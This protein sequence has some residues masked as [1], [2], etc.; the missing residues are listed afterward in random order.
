MQAKYEIANFLKQNNINDIFYL[1]GIHTISLD[2]A[3][4]AYGL[5]VIMGRHESNITFMADGYARASGKTGVL[6]VT[7]GPG[8]G[9]VV[10]GCM[11]AYGDDTPLIIFHIDTKREEHGRGILHELAEPENIFRYFIKR[12]YYVS[13]LDELIPSLKSAYT[14]ATTNRKGPTI[15]SIPFVFLDREIP[16][17]TTKKPLSAVSFTEQKGSLT[18]EEMAEKI[19][20]IIQ[21]K[22]RPVIICGKSA[23]FEYAGQTL[24]KMCMNAS[25]P[26]FIT[27]GGKGVLDE[28]L[29]CCL[30]NVIQKG[31]AQRVL[32]ESDLVIAIG[33]RL[34]DVDAKRRGVK[35]KDLIHIDLD[36]QWLNKNYPS[37]IAC[38][39]DIKGFISMLEGILHKKTF[40]W[41]LKLIKK[42]RQEERMVLLKKEK[43]YGIVEA[44]RSSIPEDTITIWDLN[45]ISYWAEYY[46]PAYKQRTFISPRGISPIFYGIPASIGAKIGVPNAPCMAISGDGGALPCLSELSTIKRYNIPVVIL[47]YN[48]ESFG[49]LE[50]MMV[51]RYNIGGSMGLVNPDFVK[52]SKDFG[53]NGKKVGSPE[54]LKKTLKAMTWDEPYVIEFK[55]PLFSPPWDT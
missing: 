33:T 55:Y 12:A 45:L 39:W 11:E 21:N 6:F 41:D 9:N 25:I 23:M 13:S 54:G 27:T 5:N 31:V 40:A 10:S 36:N 32:R 8:L 28:R 37:T 49:I 47:I 1:P 24:A 46:F 2:E 4:R 34:R 38:A 3:F 50:D 20:A 16:K 19:E 17:E 48:N 7:P 44:I 15:I 43:G 52:I 29:P 53:I 22:E 51:K 35:I 14:E 18:M 26:F 42:Q 30:G